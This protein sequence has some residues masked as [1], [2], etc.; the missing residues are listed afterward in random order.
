MH[1]TRQYRMKPALMRLHTFAA[2]SQY[3]HDLCTDPTIAARGRIVPKISSTYIAIYSDLPFFLVPLIWVKILLIMWISVLLGLELTAKCTN[4]Y[5]PMT[6]GRWY[7]TRTAFYLFT[8]LLELLSIVVIGVFDLPQVF[9]DSNA[10]VLH[11]INAVYRDDSKGT[12]DDVERELE[13]TT[14]TYLE[15]RWARIPDDG[16]EKKIDSQ[17]SA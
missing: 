9:W 2:V 12:W 5:H 7:N 3:C 16:S 15:G 14:S 8:P 1:L 10:A 6:V 4:I 17:L 11:A 13:G